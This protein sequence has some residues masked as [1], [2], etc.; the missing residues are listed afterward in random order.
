MSIAEMKRIC[1]VLFD[2]SNRIFGPYLAAIHRILSLVMVTG[3]R[4]FAAAMAAPG[5]E[6]RLLWKD[7]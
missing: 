4:L 5:Y 2:M 7:R 1:L 6:G 3:R